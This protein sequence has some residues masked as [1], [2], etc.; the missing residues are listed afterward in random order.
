MSKLIFVALTIGIQYIQYILCVAFLPKSG[1]VYVHY[2]WSMAETM[3]QTIWYSTG[4]TMTCSSPLKLSGW[5]K[6]ITAAPKFN[7]QVLFYL[8]LFLFF[9]LFQT[10]KV[11]WI[12]TIRAHKWDSF[13]DWRASESY[14]DS[15]SVSCI[16]APVEHSTFKGCPASPFNLYI[17][18]LVL[19]TRPLDPSIRDIYTDIYSRGHPIRGK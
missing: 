17:M 4:L 12:T 3:Q 16:I 6:K 14:R 1:C 11:I 15:F 2:T 10:R 18:V 9:F 8:C 13:N 5:M 7:P 19:I